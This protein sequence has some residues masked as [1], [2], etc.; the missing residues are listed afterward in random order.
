VIVGYS[1]EISNVRSKKVILKDVSLYIPYG[2]FKNWLE[3]N[4]GQT[5]NAT[6]D[7]A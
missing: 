2:D 3:S 5:Q 4:I 1:H 7:H 6:P